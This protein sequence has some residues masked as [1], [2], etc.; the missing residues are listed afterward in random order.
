[1]IRVI[2]ENVVLFF[3]PAAIYVAYVYL[4]RTDTRKGLLDEAPVIW[5]VV[6]GTALVVIVLVTF[7]STSGGRPDQVYQ[8]PV[9]KDGKIIPGHYR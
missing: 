7:G 1:M 4:T 5:L 9:L 6:A 3:L 8:P 2:V